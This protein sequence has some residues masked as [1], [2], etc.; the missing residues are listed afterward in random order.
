MSLF[1]TDF[2]NGSRRLKCIGVIPSK[3]NY[4]TKSQKRSTSVSYSLLCKVMWGRKLVDVSQLISHI[5]CLGSKPSFSLAG[6][7][8]VIPLLR[9]YSHTRVTLTDCCSLAP[10]GG[11]GAVWLMHSSLQTTEGVLHFPS[12]MTRKKLRT[13]LERNNKMFLVVLKPWRFQT[14]VYLE[15]GYRPMPTQ[16]TT[17]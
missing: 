9:P 7:V 13:P 11:L 12:L 4:C 5:I 2:N 6:K 8:P 16:N 14:V 15:T 17:S 1:W 10:T 3:C